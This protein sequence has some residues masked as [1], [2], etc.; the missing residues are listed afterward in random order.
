MSYQTT[1][2]QKEKTYKHIFKWKKPIL[3]GYTAYDLNYAL[4]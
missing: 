2:T 1:N 4:L 3:K